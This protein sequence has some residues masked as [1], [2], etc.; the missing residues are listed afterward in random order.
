MHVC[1]HLAHHKRRQRA[2][3]RG[4]HAAADGPRLRVPDGVE[5]RAWWLVGVWVGGGSVGLVTEEA[6]LSPNDP[7]LYIHYNNNL[8]TQEEPKDAQPHAAGDRGR[9]PSVAT[10]R[11]APGEVVT[12]LYWF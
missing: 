10:R 11:L 6:D 5:G 7:Q 9:R 2:P 8:R 3:A 4:A 1:T 12:H